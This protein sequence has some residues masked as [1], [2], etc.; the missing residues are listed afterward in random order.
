M[1]FAFDDEII[2]ICEECLHNRG[3]ATHRCPDECSFMKPDT[4]N[5][6][7]ECRDHCVA[8]VLATYY[9]NIAIYKPLPARLLQ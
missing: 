6:C 3:I 4:C 1:T 2:T 7:D 9:K 8:D 5:C